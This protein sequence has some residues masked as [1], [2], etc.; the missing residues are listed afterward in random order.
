MSLIDIPHFLSTTRE[1]QLTAE[2]ILARCRALAPRLRERAEDIEEQRQLPPDI[3][4]LLRGT[5]VFRMAVPKA[6]GGPE[7][8]AVQQTEVIEA[9]ATGDASTAWCA[10]IG[11]DTPVYAGF[12]R[13][14]VA[15][16][17]LA[18]PDTVTAGA[19]MP[20]GRAERTPGG[21][22]V[23]GQWH[24]G[25][26]ITHSTWVVGG[27][28]VTRDGEPEPGP[29]GTPG[30]WRVIV[31]PVED[32]RV[33]DTWYTTG[34]AGTGSRDYRAENLYV[35][36]EYTFS[37]AA[38]RVTGAAAT[39]DAVLRNMPG[40]PLGVARA[41]ID[42]IRLMATLRVDRA[43]Q[44]PWAEDYRVQTVIARS[45][46]RLSAARYAVYG[47]L[48]EQWEILE[49]GDTPTADEQVATVLARVNAFRTAR[50]VVTELFDLAA[51]SAVYRPSVLDRWLRDLT[52]MCQHVMAQDQVVQSAGAR[53][54]GGTPQNPYSVGIVP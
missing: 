48:R 36:E 29:P 24:F 13:E 49:A 54:L 53:L 21:Y 37:F 40:V 39:P 52:T 19:I 17:L 14:D 3:V 51:T 15:R 44:S 35:P 1:N 47:S 46:M 25:S 23:T 26:G 11:M 5:G 2:E 42:H 6:W 45:E 33:Q 50:S 7:L 20:M 16:R 34:L 10:M 32:F 43:S 31:A 4:E 30:N 41:A 9:L 27:V 8:D 22:R 38:P 18:D 12:L 28:L